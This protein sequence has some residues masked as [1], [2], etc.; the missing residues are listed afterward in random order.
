ME[1]LSGNTS[2]DIFNEQ[3]E[4]LV[5]SGRNPDQ[6]GKMEVKDAVT[7]G[8]SN[9]RIIMQETL[10]VV[11]LSL[12]DRPTCQVSAK[13]NTLIEA[14]VSGIWIAILGFVFP[15]LGPITTLPK[16]K[17]VL[18]ILRNSELSWRRS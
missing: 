13:A 18:W 16:S 1:A 4:L 3:L 11:V 8:E 2:K 17:A 9:P 7:I 6:F 15:G 14:A 10:E 12:T 5:A